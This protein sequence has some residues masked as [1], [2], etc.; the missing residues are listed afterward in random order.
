MTNVGPVHFL[1]SEPVVAAVVRG[2]ARTGQEVKKR[3][4]QESHTGAFSLCDHTQKKPQ[5]AQTQLQLSVHFVKDKPFFKLQLGPTPVL[6]LVKLSQNFLL[7][8]PEEILTNLL[9]LLSFAVKKQQ[10]RQKEIL[11]FKTQRA[12]SDVRCF[13]PLGSTVVLFQI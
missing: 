12:D 10:Q 4:W 5:R 13:S 11:K 3:L 9:N 8:T 7:C 2:R 6:C 1:L